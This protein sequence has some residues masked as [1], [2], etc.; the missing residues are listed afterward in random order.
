V[1]GER[2]IP[3]R[4]A[5]AFVSAD[6]AA[7]LF[8]NLTVGENVVSR[9]DEE[10]TS[11]IGVL[12]FGRMDALGRELRDRFHI[13]TASL[14]TPIRSLSGGNQQKVA[15]AAAVVCAPRV[16]V[17]EEPTRGVD[18]GSKAEIYDILRSY[19]AEGHAVVLY[20]T[21]MLE[22]FEVAASLYVVSDGA[23]SEPLDVSAFTDV[24]SLASAASALE[25]HARRTADA[26]A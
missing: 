8:T 25:R 5:T 24:E 4:D 18:I 20:C 3:L 17:L 22:V 12:R 26:A 6:R 2:T 1:D 15:I 10:I 16:L 13:K 7:S 14:E 11:G 21:E 23:L 9:L 19:A